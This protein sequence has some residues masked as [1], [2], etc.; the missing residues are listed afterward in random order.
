MVIE[1]NDPTNPQLKVTC[2]GKV[3]GA[4]KELPTALNFGLIDPDSLAVTQ[5]LALVRGDGGP[6]APKVLPPQTP[7]LSAEL[8]EIRA[9]EHYELA[10]KVSPPFAMG[11]MGGVLIVETGVPEG[12]SEGFRILGTVARR[13]QVA[14]AELR[15]P[16]HPEAEAERSARV[17]WHNAAPH[18]ILTA[19]CSDPKLEA[20]V[21]IA[22]RSQEVF[23]KVP[24]GYEVPAPPPIVTVKTDDPTHAELTIPVLTEEVRPAAK[25]ATP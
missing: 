14:P 20:R 9:G 25:T 15:L 7:G 10:V 23:L 3:R 11:Q 4:F 1:T 24:A 21:V 19:A 18:R 2:T 22:G 5:T 17:L 8:K 6:I 12:P 13:V 16:A